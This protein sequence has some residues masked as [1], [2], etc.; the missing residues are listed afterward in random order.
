MDNSGLENGIPPVIRVAMLVRRG[1]LK[2][3]TA[4]FG[5]K[6]KASLWDNSGAEFK[7]VF[8]LLEGNY[9]ITFNPSAEPMGELPD[10]LD[11][12][13]LSVYKDPSKLRHLTII[14]EYGTLDK[15]ELAGQWSVEQRGID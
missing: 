3:F 14:R 8:G 9:P 5:L 10:H 7:R 2:N 15:E 1:N 4:T 12:N 13:N 11:R 6:I